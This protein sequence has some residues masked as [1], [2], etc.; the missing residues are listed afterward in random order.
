MA[1]TLRESM[2]G[3]FAQYPGRVD[4]VRGI[5][6][7]V[8][9]VGLVSR[10]TR[11]SKKGRRYT[12]DCLTAACRLYEGA[13]VGVGHRTAGVGRSAADTLG[14]LRAVRVATDGLRGNLHYL[15]SHPMAERLCEAAEK[16]PSAFGLSHDVSKWEGRLDSDGVYVVTAIHKVESVDLVANPGTTRGL[17]ESA[18]AEETT[19]NVHDGRTF[20]LAVLVGHGARR[21]LR[22]SAAR[23]DRTLEESAGL[24]AD[25]GPGGGADGEVEDAR[26]FAARVLIGRRRR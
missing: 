12:K 25:G 2:A 17:F 9:I 1:T 5:I 13:K 15:A 7:D 26:W 21:R 3:L 14:V 4:R 8:K 24:A 11:E 23:L 19:M 16:T 6:H 10:N 22:E 18:G 20:A